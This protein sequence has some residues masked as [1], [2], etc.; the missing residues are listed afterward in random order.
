[1]RKDLETLEQEVVHTADLVIEA[2]KEILD[3]DYTAVKEVTDRGLIR[4]TGHYYYEI[5][6]HEFIFYPESQF[7]CDLRID[8][9]KIEGRQTEF[10]KLYAKILTCMTT[11]RNDVNRED[12]DRQISVLED[13]LNDLNKRGKCD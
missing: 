2:V 3:K 11:Q 12:V 13:V 5:M 7:S 10:F 1:M 9:V 8:N 6:G 4:L